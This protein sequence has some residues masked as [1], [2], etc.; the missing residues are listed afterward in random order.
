MI[1]YEISW[2]EVI[3]GAEAYRE[4][5]KAHKIELRRMAREDRRQRA[6]HKA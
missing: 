2:E 5:L 3:K 4:F 1:R 6:I